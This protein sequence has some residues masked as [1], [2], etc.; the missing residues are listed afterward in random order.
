[1]FAESAP[2][3]A[4]GAV[5]LVGMR[6][7]EAGRVTD[8][9]CFLLVI[10]GHGPAWIP[11]LGDGAVQ[12]GNPHEVLESLRREAEVRLQ[13]RRAPTQG[14]STAALR[15]TSDSAPLADLLRHEDGPGLL[16]A[17]LECSESRAMRE[18]VRG[19]LNGGR[20]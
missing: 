15:E 1:M 10:D 8:A 19:V 12:A 11:I 6:G 9:E 20:A 7:D 5:A 16:R 2:P 3:S 18:L 17:V 14:E 13:G 4:P